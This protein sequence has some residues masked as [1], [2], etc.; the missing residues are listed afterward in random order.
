MP[1]IKP[2][3]IVGF[4]PLGVILAERFSYSLSD[5]SLVEAVSFLSIDTHWQ[6][7]SLLCLINL[8]KQ[9]RIL[10]SNSSKKFGVNVHSVKINEELVYAYIKLATQRVQ[11]YYLNLLK[12]RQ[13]KF[14]LFNNQIENN[15]RLK[16]NSLNKYESTD[17]KEIEL[18]CLYNHSSKSLERLRNNNDFELTSKISWQSYFHSATTSENNSTYVT[19]SHSS[20][21]EFD[22]SL[23]LNSFHAIFQYL[24]QYPS[25]KLIGPDIFA[26]EFAHLLSSLGHNQIYLYRMNPNETSILP[27][28]KTNT[29]LVTLFQIFSKF[30]HKPLIQTVSD[31]KHRPRLHII[32]QFH[33]FKM[34]L[35]A[36]GRL[37]YEKFIE[38]I[39]PMSRTSDKTK[40]NKQTYLETF[41][42]SADESTLKLTTSDIQTGRIY[43]SIF[44]YKICFIQDEN[45]KIQ[46]EPL[47]HF[48]PSSTFFVL[49]DVIT[50]SDIKLHKQQ[51]PPPLPKAIRT[52][53]STPGSLILNIY[54][55]LRTMSG[56]ETIPHLTNIFLSVDHELCVLQNQIT[57]KCTDLFV[58]IIF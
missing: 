48:P 13:V 3:Q 58:L 25:V 38:P 26:F 28:T 43:F 56:D 57:G 36:E 50:F 1:S 15:Q 2:I 20:H 35:N 14:E 6:S 22:R 53:N 34:N 46:E 24:L 40:K 5:I 41:R 37:E 52:F 45:N 18:N 10:L 33:Q 30:I 19:Y 44:L 11:K 47:D 29:T 17:K 27:I 39:I 16:E 4:T 7:V 23:R 8:L 55:T 54:E 12:Q 42:Q 9:C 49:T 51:S 32:E 21:S 31:E